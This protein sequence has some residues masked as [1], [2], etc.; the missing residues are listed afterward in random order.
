MK[1]LIVCDIDGSLMPPSAG[2]TVSTA[3]QDRLIA[4]EKQG[5]VVVLNTARVF[6]GAY[7]LAKQVKMDVFGGFIIASNGCQIYEV[8]SQ[9]DI[10][11]ACMDQEQVKWLWELATSMD[12]GFGFS[13]KDC[14]VCNR[15]E[16]GF[17]LD[18]K[19]CDVDYI[20]TNH[21][22]K[23]MKDDIV[24]CAFAASEAKLVK[25]MSEIEDEIKK[26]TDFTVIKSTPLLYDIINQQESK[27]RAVEILLN[28]LGA[29]WNDVTAIGDGYSDVEIIQR[30]G[31][32]CTLE[33]GKQE[34]K[35]VADLIVP[36]CYEDGCLVWLDK[37]LE[38]KR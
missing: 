38:E 6:Q 30:A 13:Q 17:Q 14:F 25:S 12:I 35:E 22:E 7:S 21:F 31:F 11:K 19:N 29:D 20:I 37:L 24:K 4:L 23:Y 3:V 34:C 32:G 33:N 10:Y 16:E 26:R 36:S 18:Q 9:K 15:M 5:D 28:L 2:L 8:S 27:Y 1:R